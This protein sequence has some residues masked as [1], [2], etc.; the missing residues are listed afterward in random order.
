MRLLRLPAGTV[1]SKGQRVHSSSNTH[2]RLTADSW[3][4]LPALGPCRLSPTS[5]AS[6]MDAGRPRA[7]ARTR[8]GR[9][10]SWAIAERGQVVLFVSENLHFVSGARLKFQM[11][12]ALVFP[13]ALVQQKM[14]QKFQQ[15]SLIQM[16]LMALKS[17]T[18]HQQATYC[19]PGS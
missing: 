11:P 3:K 10:L 2:S 13:C 8:A 1:G 12:R 14:P 7:F 4:S 5:T 6:F 18:F 17:Q 15:I 19:S 9:A 16:K